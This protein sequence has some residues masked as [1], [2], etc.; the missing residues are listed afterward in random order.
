MNAHSGES[1]GE[2]I[3]TGRNAAQ[4]ALLNGVRHLLR[5]AVMQASVPVDDALIDAAVK[6][7]SVSVPLS[8]EQ[9]ADL[10]KIQNTLSALI[11]P[12]RPESVIAIDEMTIDRKRRP[13]F[14]RWW[15]QDA[16]VR[17]EIRRAISWVLAVLIPLVFIQCYT[18]ALSSV[19]TTIEASEVSLEKSAVE[20]AR[21]QRALADAKKANVDMPSLVLEYNSWDEK[22]IRDETIVI[23]SYD[24][25]LKFTW[26]WSSWVFPTDATKDGYSEAARTQQ[27]NIRNASQAILKAIALY[28]LPLL[29]GLLGAN[30]YILRQLITKLDLWNL[31]L[32]SVSKH[33]LR[34]ALGVLLGAIVGL[35]FDS[36]ESAVASTG[37][38]LASL[39][40]LAGYSSEFIFSV[41]DTFIE[42][43][44]GAFS[45]KERY[46]PSSADPEGS[47]IA[48]SGKV[49]SNGR[50]D[51]GN[52]TNGA[53]EG[54][55]AA[56]AKEKVA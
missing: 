35:V 5:F 40:F 36:N 21:V 41:L 45:E 30:V 46:Q 19:L 13:G 54:A 48:L 31:D 3:A 4:E 23:A 50:R 15:S 34:R 29:Y 17:G 52:G 6:A 2:T 37:F 28:L 39:A 8:P 53:A 20:V 12:A 1:K 26:F 14:W 18:L 43:A 22:S 47:A 27:I 51:A 55:G 44:K 32:L 24:M 38:G 7:T 11:H 10:W 16:V 42:R 25:L 9:E 56:V 49:A 33:H